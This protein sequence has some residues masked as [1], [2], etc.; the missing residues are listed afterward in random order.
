MLTVAEEINLSIKKKL[1]LYIEIDD[2]P[3][4][5]HYYVTLA[6]SDL[7][8]ERYHE[9]LYDY[10][11]DQEKFEYNL[12]L[13]ENVSLNEV[14]NDTIPWAD[15]W[16][17]RSVFTD[18]MLSNTL[19]NQMLTYD[20]EGITDDVSSLRRQCSLLKVACYLSGSYWFKIDLT[21]NEL[22]RAFLQIDAFLNKDPVAK[23]RVFV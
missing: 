16:L 8:T 14:I 12:R 15:L 11:E 3:N 19:C 7:D 2:I 20:I 22:A 5:N 6:V 18:E 21:T 10:D 9:V 17:D 4:S 23:K 13:S 1:F